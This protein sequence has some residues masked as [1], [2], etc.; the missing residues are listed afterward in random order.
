MDLPDRLL[1]QVA[2]TRFWGTGEKLIFFNAH[3]FDLAHPTGPDRAR[4]QTGNGEG[5][6]VDDRTER[7]STNIGRTHQFPRVHN[8]GIQFFLVSI[9]R[10]GGL[11]TVPSCISGKAR[12]ILPGR[13]PP[14]LLS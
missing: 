13:V 9:S 11:H 10:M 5:P 7:F 14:Q 6:K 3:T 12:T 8:D 4:P 1:L 2:G